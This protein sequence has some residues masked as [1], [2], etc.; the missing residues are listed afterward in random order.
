[1]LKIQNLHAFYGKSHILHGVDMEVK[2]GEIVSL[3][4][5]NGSG[6]STTIKTIMGLVDGHARFASCTASTNVQCAILT[7]NALE[8]LSEDHPRTAVKLMFAVS[9]RISER[10]RDTTEKLRM[11]GQLTQAMQQEI[12]SLM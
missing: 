1:M 7:R 6:R 5:R 4:G 8:K 2:P 3:L 12:D 9:L 10:L 11:Y